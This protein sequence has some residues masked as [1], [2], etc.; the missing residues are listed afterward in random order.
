MEQAKIATVL[1]MSDSD[2]ELK[3]Y[4]LPS[5]PRSSS[6][7]AGI[8]DKGNVTCLSMGMT[9]TDPV[10]IEKLITGL[11]FINSHPAPYYLHCNEGKDRTG[12]ISVLLEAFMG[13]GQDE[14]VKDYMQSYLN[15]YGVEENT[16]KYTIIA[17]DNVI[18]MLKTITNTDNLKGVN[19]SKAARDYLLGHSMSASEADALRRTL[20]TK[21]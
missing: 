2:D 14:I 17:E 10:F 21:L 5:N 11:R 8:L 12:F 6:Y 7:Y 19:L 1:N 13:A 20:G 15:Y 3:A 16:A 9:F 4:L 18:S